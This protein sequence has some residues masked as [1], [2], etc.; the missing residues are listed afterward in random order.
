[1]KCQNWPLAMSTCW[2]S[3]PS[4]WCSHGDGMIQVNAARATRRRASLQPSFGRSRWSLLR[5]GRHCG[6]RCSGAIDASGQL[7]SFGANQPANLP[8]WCSIRRGRIVRA[9]Q[10][11]A[12]TV[13]WWRSARRI[14]CCSRRMV[15]RCGRGVITNRCSLDGPTRR[16]RPSFAAAF[17]SR[18]RCTKLWRW[19]D[20][21]RCC[22]RRRP[23][24][25]F[26]AMVKH[27]RGVTTRLANAALAVLVPIHRRPRIFLARRW[28]CP[29]SC[30]YHAVM[31]SSSDCTA[32][33]M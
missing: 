31:A 24:R 8:L 22:V 12:S 29:Y 33:A 19:S 27:G 11:A 2:R 18:R 20:H 3:L 15:R 25:A 26:R 14:A 13:K 16:Q 17:K 23:R 7:W 4:G 28:L 5:R 21:H 10:G 1:M 6:P 30:R 9:R 32:L